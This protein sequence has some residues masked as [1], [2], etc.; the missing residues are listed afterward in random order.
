MS[1]QIFPSRWSLFSALRMFFYCLLVVIALLCASCGDDNSS[2]PSRNEDVGS[3]VDVSASSSSHDAKS[4]SSKSL[5]PEKKSSSSTTLSSSN[6]HSGQSMKSTDNEEES[7]SS[8]NRSSSSGKKDL[9]SSSNDSDKVSESVKPVES[10]SSSDKSKS[11]SSENSS[12]DETKSS[13]SFVFS[14]DSTSN[15]SE[16]WVKPTACKPGSIMEPTNCGCIMDSLPVTLSDYEVFYDVEEKECVFK[17]KDDSLQVFFNALGKWKRNYYREGQSCDE[18]EN[19]NGFF[20]MFYYCSSRPGIV[21]AVLYK[22]CKHAIE[23][24]QLPTDPFPLNDLR[25]WNMSEFECWVD[26]EEDFAHTTVTNYRA[27]L[28]NIEASGW[29]E[30]DDCENGSSRLY[31]SCYDKTVDSYNLHLRVSWKDNQRIGFKLDY[32]ESP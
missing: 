23:F 2:G 11:S 1:T 10:S 12:G 16:N 24:A 14:S 28:S 30:S 13:S 32:S 20:A 19:Y 29:N 3:G 8:R 9:S 6:N 15:I 31:Y 21:S 7:S 18:V 26:D 4:S 27:F 5:L 22:D 17:A 25:F